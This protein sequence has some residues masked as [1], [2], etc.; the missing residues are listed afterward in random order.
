MDGAFIVDHI[1]RNA[2]GAQG[3]PIGNALVAQGVIAADD[4][5]RWCQAAVIGGDQGGERRVGGEV[6]ATRI[7][8]PEPGDILPG[9]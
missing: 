2:G 5:F 1:R 4:D 7:L 3:F 8:F 6:L 9:P